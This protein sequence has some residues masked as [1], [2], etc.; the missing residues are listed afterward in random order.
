MNRWIVIL[1]G[2]LLVQL[3]GVV[4]VNMGDDKYAAFQPEEKLLAFDPGSIDGLRI[5][6]DAG[7]LLLKRENGR[8]SMPDSDSFPA[9]KDGV[10]RLL[11]KLGGL[12]KGWPVATTSGAAKRFKVDDG[13]FERKLE[14]LAGSE[15]VAT[16]Y[17]G[18]SPG[19]RKVHV[20]VAGE[21]DVHAVELESWEL[22]S[23]PD[24]WIDRSV[25]VLDKQEI[26]RLEMPGFALQR[27]GDHLQLE[28]L[29]EGEQ[30][31]A[32]AVSTLLDRVA[33]LRIQSLLGS[34]PSADYGQEKPL[35][36]FRIKRKGGDELIYRISEPADK[37][38]Y[39][40]KRSDIN[41]YLKTNRY[42]I[43]PILKTTREELLL[44]GDDKPGDG[45]SSEKQ[46]AEEDGGAEEE[47][48]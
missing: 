37:E 44:K 46:P 27:N 30:T 3:A 39:V 48:Q 43:D 4:A 22:T 47:E 11:E 34:E 40:L 45:T 35:L 41:Y 36:E 23:R 31:D 6:D 28:G 24:E 26:E 21:D 12:K 10:E 7:A 20:R 2:L 9:R 19:L 1:G 32:K 17:V 13:Q 15:G 5:E 18:S 29:P 33:G 16:L 14:L 42:A 25:T 38:Y 8:W